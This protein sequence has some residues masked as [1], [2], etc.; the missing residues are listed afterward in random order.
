L[1]LQLKDRQQ[2]LP[3][4]VEALNAESFAEFGEVIE[5]GANPAEMINSGHTEKFSRLATI[6]AAE[7]DGQPAVH[8]Y[9]SQ[10][11]LLPLLLTVMEK[12]PLS[13]QAFMPLHSRPFLVI[14]ARPGD[15]LESHAVRAFRSNGKQGIN[16]R[17]GIWHH[18]Q[19]S[20]GE[21]SEYLV[22]DRVGQGKNLEEQALRPPRVI[23]HL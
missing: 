15:Q 9:R 1:A 10:P 2:A 14:V 4:T 19:V 12:H 8:I 17:R 7:Q 22:I 20:L 18:Y 13:S 5:I 21:V 11:L 16:L 3:L 6:D 23:D